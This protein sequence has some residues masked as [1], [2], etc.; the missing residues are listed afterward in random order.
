MPTSSQRSSTRKRHLPHLPRPQASVRP[1]TLHPPL[2][3]PRPILGEARAEL[4]KAARTDNAQTSTPLL[5]PF[6]HRTRRMCIAS[7]P[8]QS[9]FQA[10]RQ[11]KLVSNS[12][13]RAAS[14]PAALPLRLPLPVVVVVNLCTFAHCVTTHR[15]VT[16]KAAARANGAPPAAVGKGELPKRTKDFRYAPHTLRLTHHTSPVAHSRQR[17]PSHPR[18]KLRAKFLETAL[19]YQGVPYSK[20]YHKEPSCEFRTV[21]AALAGGRSRR[22]EFAA[23]TRAAGGW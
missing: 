23:I 17:L 20:R 3:H 14:L 22:S 2:T 9:S 10:F 15:S 21:H 7:G 18:D 11:K 13:N 6:P 4:S 5:S 1:G 16:C 8:L 19:S 12:D